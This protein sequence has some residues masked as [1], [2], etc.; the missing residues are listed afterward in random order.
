MTNDPLARAEVL[1]LLGMNVI[2]DEKL[3]PYEWY[4]L[5]RVEIVDIT[6]MD[7]AFRVAIGGVTSSVMAKREI[8]Y[9]E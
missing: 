7:S 6:P 8:K 9:Y 5:E 1:S 3:D 2:L 4:I